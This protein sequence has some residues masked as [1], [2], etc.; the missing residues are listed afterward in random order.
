MHTVVLPVDIKSRCFL[1][2]LWLAN[3][4][5]GDRRTIS[6]ALPDI[7][8]DFYLAMGALDEKTRYFKKLKDNSVII[9]VHDTEGMYNTSAGQFINKYSSDAL[10]LADLHFSWGSSQSEALKKK[11][12]PDKIKTV[13]SGSP[14]FDLLHPELNTIYS[15]SKNIENTDKFLL[16]ITNFTAVN[17][18]DSNRNM[19]KSDDYYKWERLT[20]EKYL[21]YI[22]EMNKKFEFPIIIRPH[23]AESPS[24][25]DVFASNHDNVYVRDEGSVRS[26]LFSASAVIHSGSTVA[27]ESNIMGKPTIAFNPEPWHQLPKET[28]EASYSISSMKELVTEVSSIFNKQSGGRLKNPPID[29]II[30]D[31]LYNCTEVKS[32]EIISNEIKKELSNIPKKEQDEISNY[33][34]VSVINKMAYNHKISRY[35]YRYSNIISGLDFLFSSSTPSISGQRFNMFPELTKKEITSYSSTVILSSDVSVRRVGKWANLFEISIKNDKY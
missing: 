17:N 13:V 10:D 35:L 31:R 30:G 29:E 14:R 25:Y 7:E 27:I 20:M 33:N 12:G 16:V 22:T 6:K 28:S 5:I 18:Y 11:Y 9:G 15:E 34:D 24:P 4:I 1:G 19:D 3:T 23:P 2:K 8:P 21:E 26:Y 32:A